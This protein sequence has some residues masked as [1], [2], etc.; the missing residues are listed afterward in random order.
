MQRKITDRLLDA[1]MT[2]ERLAGDETLFS[3]V[4]RAFTRTAPELLASINAALGGN[5][6]K[7]AFTEAHSLKGAVAAFEAPQVLNSV[8]N[9]ERHARN[10]DAAAVAEALPVAQALVQRLLAELAPMAGS[11]QMQAQA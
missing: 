5:D 9:V 10:D 7:R 4:A 3:V 6:L 2:L 8:L 11:T 1:D